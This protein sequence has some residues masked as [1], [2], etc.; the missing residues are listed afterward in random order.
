MSRVYNLGIE[1]AFLNSYDGWDE[2]DVGIQF[3]NC[4][5]RLGY[6]Q[7]DG[8]TLHL[9]YADARMEVYRGDYVVFSDAIKLVRC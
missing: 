7:Y 5:F 8:C 1:K 3:Y 4:D 9:N 6:G 2:T